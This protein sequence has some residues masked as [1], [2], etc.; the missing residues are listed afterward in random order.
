MINEGKVLVLDI[1]G[2]ICELKKNG[3]SYL[4]LKPINDVLEKIN[5]YRKN[6]FKIILYTARNMRAHQGNVGKINANTLKDL[7]NWLEK[8]NIEYDEIHVGKPWAG[9]EGFYIDDRAI[10]PSEFLEKT[11][12]EIADLTGINKK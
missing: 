1:D 10:R 11:Y 4:D 8:H 3:Q 12:D 6:G 9:K 5:E 2:T 7:F